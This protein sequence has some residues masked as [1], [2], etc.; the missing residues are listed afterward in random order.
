MGLIG[1]AILSISVFLLFGNVFHV[2]FF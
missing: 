2:L 1:S